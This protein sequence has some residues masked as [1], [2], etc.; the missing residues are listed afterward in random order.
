MLPSMN[1]REAFASVHQLHKV[2]MRESRSRVANS[3]EV[4]FKERLVGVR[5]LRGL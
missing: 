2:E 1:K 4:H 3:R 5:I